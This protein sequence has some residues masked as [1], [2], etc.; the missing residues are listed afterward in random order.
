MENGLIIRRALPADSSAILNLTNQLGYHADDS[1]I[2]IRLKNIS[3]KMDHCVLVAL[4]GQILVG[5][6]HAFYTLRVESDPFVEIGGL[7]IDEQYRRKGIGTLFL[8]SVIDWSRLKE[9]STI[10]VRCNTIRQE[11]HLFYQQMGFNTTKDQRIFEKNF[12]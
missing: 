10:R 9:C 3:E 5:W 7:V 1:A 11:S 6:I 4:T 8:K 12:V 2:K